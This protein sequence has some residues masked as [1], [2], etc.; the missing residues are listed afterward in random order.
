MLIKMQYRNHLGE[1]IDF[2]ETGFYVNTG[3]LL[4]YTWTVKTR[5]GKISGMSRDVSNR[6]LPVFIS[7]ASAQEG[8]DAK[9]RLFEVAEKDVLA[10]QPGR[11]IIGDYYY[12]CYVTASKKSSSRNQSPRYLEAELVITSD[13]DSW[14]REIPYEF[15]AKGGGGAAFLDYSYDYPID[16]LS[17]TASRTLNNPGFVGTDFRLIIFGACENPEIVVSGHSYQVLASAEQGEYITIDSRE[18]TIFKTGVDGQQTNLFNSRN[19]ESYIFQRIPAG[20]NPVTWGGEF[21]FTITIL[22]ERSEPKWT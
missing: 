11:I 16:F 19:K 5:G 3:E 14:I 4:N 12:P 17:S 13:C 7:C 1:T 8:L 6:N 20:S 15:S 18:K 2:G 22:E 10:L 21:D 9:N